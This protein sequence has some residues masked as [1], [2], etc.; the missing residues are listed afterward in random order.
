MGDLLVPT[1][2]SSAEDFVRQ[3][4]LALVLFFVPAG[5]APTRYVYTFTTALNGHAATL[6][7]ESDYASANLHH[8]IDLTFGYDPTE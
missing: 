5:Y 1:W 6:Y 7:Q 8:W 3:H 2:A 4:R